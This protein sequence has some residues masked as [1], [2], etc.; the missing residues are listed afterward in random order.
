MV[1]SIS[2]A[3]EKPAFSYNGATDFWVWN[4][5][6]CENVFLD[7]E[8]LEMAKINKISFI[9]IKSAI[10]TISVEYLAID[11]IKV[12]ESHLGGS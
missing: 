7:A 3:S 10:V 11:N 12:I 9:D 4:Y 6:D 8:Y 1:N 2:A 5:K